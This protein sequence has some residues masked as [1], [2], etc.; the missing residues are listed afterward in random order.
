MV[1][2][3][4]FLF[5]GFLF[6]FGFHAECKGQVQIVDFSWYE[7][8]R[9]SKS[10]TTYVVNFWATWCV[11]CVKELPEFELIHKKYSNQKVKV[12]LVS[13]DYVKALDKSVLPLVKKQGLRSKVVLLNETN[14]NTYIDKVDASWTGSLPATLV[15]NNAHSFYLFN[16][17]PLNFAE[18]EFEIKKSLKL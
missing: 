13:L 9:N 8:L 17:K 11:P 16:E 6:T 2:L 15:F 14:P 3:I 4:G 1:K 10:D 5:L 12:I 7:S 18:L